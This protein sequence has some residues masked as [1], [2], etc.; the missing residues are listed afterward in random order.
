M[1]QTEKIQHALDEGDLPDWITRKDVLLIEDATGDPAAEVTLIV[2]EGNESVF[3]DGRILNRV[4]DQVHKIFHAIQ[5]ERW[6][7]VS[8]VA[9]AEA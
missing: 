9:E 6:P 2:R 8:F 5:V 4:R 1:T 3:Q 7:Y